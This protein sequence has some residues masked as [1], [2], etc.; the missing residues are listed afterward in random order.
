MKIQCNVCESSEAAVLCCADEAALCWSCDEKVHAA[1]KLASKHQRVPLSTSTSQMPKCDICQEAAGYFFC[2][3][4]R[5]LLCRNCDVAIHTVNSLVSSHQRFLL[6]GVKVGLEAADL[7]ASSSTGKSTSGEKILEP[8]KPHSVPANQFN[9][10]MP[11]EA[12][13]FVPSKMPY[14]GG[15]SAD[16]IQWQFDDFL[17]LTDYNQNYN[18]LD[19]DSSKA[20]SGK[21]GESDG[22]PILRA[23]DIE[24]DDEECLGQVPDASWAVPQMSSP[25]TASGLSWPKDRPRYQHPPGSDTYVPD[26][27]YLPMPNFYGSRQNAGASQSGVAGINE[28]KG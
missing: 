19:N 18:Y 2:L 8:E 7:G 24:L 26:V 5:A 10:V 25:P 17:A 22:S 20:D 28:C 6:T 16:S 9:K 15:S 13:D 11:V 3:E 12:G 27:C 14:T 1:N 23:M 4:D 21:L